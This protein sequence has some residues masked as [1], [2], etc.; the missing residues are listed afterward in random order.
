MET[1][2]NR[3]SIFELDEIYKYKDLI[4]A[5]DQV[6]IKE[7]ICADD[8]KSEHLHAEFLKLVAK[9]VDHELNKAQFTDLKDK[10]VAEMKQHL[11]SK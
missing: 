7:I 10:L 4:E 9:E 8:E 11:E 6:I 2:D 5:T 3:A 1:I